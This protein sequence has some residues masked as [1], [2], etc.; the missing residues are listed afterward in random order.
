MVFRVI[1]LRGVQPQS[2]SRKPQVP[3]YRWQGSVVAAEMEGWVGGNSTLK[4]KNSKLS[5]A[6]PE[7]H[8]PG[9]FGTL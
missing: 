1:G 8:A 4:T 5:E 3:P 9:P 7:P 6:S 2:A